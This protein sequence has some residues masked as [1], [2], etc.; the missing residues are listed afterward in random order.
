M[1][2]KKQHISHSLLMSYL[3][4]EADAVQIDEVD[5]WL[6]L[7]EDNAKYLKS[8]EMVWIETGKL[9]PP[10]VAVDSAKAWENVSSELNF[11]SSKEFKT[12]IRKIN[13]YKYI[14]QVAAI[15]VVIIG[16]YSI[17]KFL[18]G[19]IETKTLASGNQIIT[20]TLNDGSVISLNKNSTLSYPEK[21][22]KHIR[23]VKLEGEAFFE[24]EHIENQ[25]FII[26]L[27]NA[28]IKVLGTSFN[29][30]EIPKEDLTV[31]YVKTGTVQLFTVN[32]ERDTSS[33]IINGGEKGIINTKSCI[34]EKQID[35]GMNA[36][37]ISWFNNTFVFDGVRLDYVA[38]FLES[39]YDTDIEFAQDVIKDHLLTATFKN[40]D[41]EEI[42]TVIAGSFGLE[43]KKEN[44]TFI[45]N[46][47]EN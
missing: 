45:L 42:M 11:K 20:D 2:K 32:A 9:I 15:F 7:S 33:V 14:L 31:V 39:Y 4:G 17:F 41:I 10:P 26:E 3:L 8:L 18:T 13:Y 38:E 47:L 12:Q 36:N 23:K 34:A 28:N 37:D 27:N 24:V 46:E 16:A 1:N 19:N 40:D 25:S 43:V 44:H 22:D 5:N 29:I 21:F 30:K 6:S 35:K